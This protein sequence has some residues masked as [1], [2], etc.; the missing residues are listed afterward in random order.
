MTATDQ[1]SIQILEVVIRPKDRYEAHPR[2][3]FSPRGE[4]V[5]ENFLGGRHTR[6]YG[7]FRPFVMKAMAMAAAQGAVMR[8]DGEQAPK[9]AWRQRAGCSCPCSPGFVLTNVTGDHNIYVQYAV[10][11]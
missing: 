7:A 3:Y 6:P 8:M 2:L 10:E 5:M 11:A 4:T 1:T 9:A